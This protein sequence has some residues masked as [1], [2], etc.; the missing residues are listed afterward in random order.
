MAFVDV[1]VAN[2]SSVQDEQFEMGLEIGTMVVFGIVKGFVRN[3]LSL[4]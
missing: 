2:Q 1:L 3:E 4:M